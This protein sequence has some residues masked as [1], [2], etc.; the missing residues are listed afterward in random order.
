ML[1]PVVEGI[2]EDTKEKEVWHRPRFAIENALKRCIGKS[3]FCLFI[4]TF[5]F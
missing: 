3:F 1:I 2:V 4:T 5:T